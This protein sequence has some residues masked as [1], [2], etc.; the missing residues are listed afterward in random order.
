MATLHAS[1]VDHR[2]LSLSPDMFWLLI[3]QGFARHINNDA[4]LLRSQ[5][6]Q[7]RGQEKIVIRRD[8]FVKDSPAN[9]WGEV[10]GAF[11]EE[12]RKRIGDVNHDNIVAAFSTTG[13]VEKAANEVALMDA[14]RS[15]FE[16]ECR[17][18]CGIPQVILEGEPEDWR[19][20][21][22]KTSR[23]GG[24]YDVQWWTDRLLVPLD[25]IVAN[26]EG[27]DCADVWRSLYKY[28]EG[29]GGSYVTGWIIDFFPYLQATAIF[30]R[31]SDDV[32][33]WNQ[34]PADEQLSILDDARGAQ[35]RYRTGKRDVRNWHVVDRSVLSIKTHNLPGSL[36][37]A[38]F[39]WKYLDQD[40][41][42]EFV[43]GF[44]AFTQAQDTLAVRPKIG[45]AVRE[46]RS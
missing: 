41:D 18:I 25:R 27:E 28:E 17:T 14:M 44:V 4:E 6:V 35:K 16:Y 7:H 8:D 15:Y 2:P 38:A 32:V 11:S 13:A 29:S 5:F 46:C 39:K 21:R 26:A 10:L 31:D 12:I 24:T 22:E 33:D 9:P 42:M 19:R 20:L 3:V 30:D 37:K 34:M 23:L 40:Y 36:S 1:F 43:A 45:W